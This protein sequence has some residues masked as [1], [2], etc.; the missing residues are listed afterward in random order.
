MKLLLTT[1]N[2]KFVHSNLA[3]RYLKGYSKDKIQTELREYTINQNIDYIVSEI[4]KIDPSFFLRLNILKRMTFQNI[5][6]NDTAPFL[7][8]L[9]HF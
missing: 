1:L 6:L 4:Y 9:L 8:A 7:K 3:L 5:N 2:S